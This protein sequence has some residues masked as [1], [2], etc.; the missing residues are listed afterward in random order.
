MAPDHVHTLTVSKSSLDAQCK[1]TLNTML[2]NGWDKAHTPYRSTQQL[3][4]LG[5]LSHLLQH[6]GLALQSG[7]APTL[8]SFAAPKFGPG[9]GVDVEFQLNVDLL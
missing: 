2:R 5:E 7:P 6:G 8:K 9:A 1:K 4:S 3:L